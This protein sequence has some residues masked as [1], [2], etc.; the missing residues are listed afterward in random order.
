Q[1]RDARYNGLSGIDRY[2]IMHAVSVSGEWAPDGDGAIDSKHPW[3]HTFYKKQPDFIHVNTDK[4]FLVANP[5]ITLQ[6]AYEKDN[7]NNPLITSNRGL[8]ARGLIAKKVGF[9]TFFTDNQEEVPSFV[10]EYADSG[11]AVPGADFYTEYTYGKYDY[12]LARGYIDFALVK[13]HINATFGYDKFFFGD[14]MRSLFLSDFTAG[15]TFLRL[16][17]RIWKLNYQNLFMELTPQYVRGSDRELPHKYAT[18]HHLS[19]NAT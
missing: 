19:I 10:A 13:D 11:Q 15:A 17:T 5:V 16:N 4:F 12:L 6:G 8:E 1:R 18:M 2:N 7:P 9:Y 14:G 3:F